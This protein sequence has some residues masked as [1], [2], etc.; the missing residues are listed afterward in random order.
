MVDPESTGPTSKPPENSPGF[1]SFTIMASTGNE[2]IPDG[3]LCPTVPNRSNYI[4]WIEDLLASDIIS[5]KCADGGL[6]RGFDI[7]TGANCI[8]PLLGSS[9]G[10]SFVGSGSF[11]YLW[12]MDLFIKLAWSPKFSNAVQDLIRFFAAN[13]F[14]DVTD[15]AL[16]WAEKN[17][18]NNP[19]ISELIEIRKVDTEERSSF[20]LESHSSQS[21]DRESSIHLSET[22]AE[23]TECS[24]STLPELRSGVNKSYYGPPMLVGV[25]KEGERFDFCMCNP[26]FFETMEKAGLNPK[27]SCGGTPQE[28]V[29]PGGELAF[30]SCIIE[31]SVELKQSFRWYTSMVGR[32]SNLKILMSKLREVGVTIIKTTEF[33]QGQTC[34]WGLAWSFISPA[35]KIISSHMA[36][37]NNLSFMLEGLQRQYTAI[38]VLQSVESFFSAVGASCKSNSSTFN[39]EVTVTKDHFDLIMKGERPK[40][41]EA[42][43][44]WYEVEK[45]NYPRSLGHPSDDLCFRIL[46]FQQIPGTLLVK[47]S[48]QHKESPVSGAFSLIF[49]QLEVVLKDKFCTEKASAAASYSNRSQ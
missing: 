30:I 5:N 1:C 4:H 3:Q 27:T 46:V 42:G 7:G 24:N 14:A 48:L 12:N 16:E 8:Y 28:M 15:V 18:K 10:W 20:K 47:G 29:C 32:K 23:D 2:W 22:K 33:V 41:N 39:V 43:S 9:L 38:Q 35:K 19:H 40:I 49:Q 13:S 17:V 37:K 6:V 26:P 44:C 34:R 36:Q 11:F 31:D 21:V 45:F 25:V